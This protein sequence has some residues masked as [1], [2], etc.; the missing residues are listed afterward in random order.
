MQNDAHDGTSVFVSGK[1]GIHRSNT[2]LPSFASCSAPATLRYDPKTK[3]FTWRVDAC[4]YCAHPHEHGGGAFWENPRRHLGPRVPH[5][6]GPHDHE[7]RL[8]ES[9][10]A[11][12]RATLKRHG[13][14]LTQ[15]TRKPKPR[16]KSKPRP[17]TARQVPR[18]KGWGRPIKRAPRRKPETT[19]A[20]IARHVARIA[21]RVAVDGPA[22]PNRARDER[23]L[24]ILH[25][26]HAKA[27]ASRG[28]NCTTKRS[29]GKR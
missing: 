15:P 20:A 23:H 25:D 14:Y 5:C 6:P 27:L 12:T 7:Y 11:R 28:I 10:P 19:A 29:D 26:R 4:P 22:Y 3:H 1:I 18:R 8:T 2:E 24:A 13:H 21:A 17:A 9:S 16:P